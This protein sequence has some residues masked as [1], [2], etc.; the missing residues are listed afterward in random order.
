MTSPVPLRPGSASL[1]AN[2]SP[3]PGR[4]RPFPGSITIEHEAGGRRVL[5]LSGDVD[6]AT[7]AEYESRQGSMLVVVDVIDAGAVTF[8]GSA[9]LGVMV[10]C[11]EASV[12]VGR[13][14]VLRA[15]SGTVER[16]AAGGRDEDLLLEARAGPRWRRGGGTGGVAVTGRPRPSA[17]QRTLDTRIGDDQLD[18]RLVIDGLECNSCGLS[19]A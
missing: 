16:L 5:C 18:R 15:A 6:S 9:G 1:E 2:M 11:A 19:V 10:R 4:L 7:V 3:H 8:L 14:P 17:V 12:A 13:L